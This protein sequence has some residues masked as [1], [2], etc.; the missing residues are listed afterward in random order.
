MRLAENPSANRLNPSSGEL[1]EA[2]R[3]SFLVPRIVI[4]AR[5]T[6]TLNLANF[7]CDEAMAL[8]IL[9]RS[10]HPPKGTTMTILMDEIL[11][12]IVDQAY[13]AACL[14]RTGDLPDPELIFA[15][16]LAELA[17]WMSS[18]SVRPTADAGQFCP[19]PGVPR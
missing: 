12:D 16:V 17:G 13:G 18:A 14:G 6:G 10:G 4:N 8:V 9:T 15:D 3:P 5:C 11:Q 2:P 1:V 19:L 7:C